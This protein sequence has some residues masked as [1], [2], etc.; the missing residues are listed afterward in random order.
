[1]R[2]EQFFLEGLGHQS[3][4]VL[5]ESAHL[6]AVVDPRRDVD[7]YLQAAEAADAR[8]GWVFETHVHNDYITGALELCERT[9]AII[10]NAASAGLAYK[11]QGARDGDRIAV[12]SLAFVVLATPGH[13]PDHLSYALY[14]SERETPT[15]VFTGGSMLVGGAGRTDLVSPGM[16]VTL[17]R[18]Q[19][20]SLRRLLDTL[21]SETLVYPT[22]GAGSFCGATADGP[23][24]RHSTIGQERLASPA[25]HAHDEAEFVRQQISGY[26]VY[27]TYYRYMGEINQ[28]GPRIL[29]G[30]PEL[31]ALTPQAVSDYL[32]HGLPLIDGRRRR[33]FAAEHVPGALNIE[34]DDSFG[35][36][37]GWLLP[38]NK[39]LMLQ[40]DD[41]TGR[42]EAVAQLIRI[43]YEQLRGH[44]EGGV[45]AWKAAGFPTRCFET[46]TIDELE[47]RWQTQ[48][49]RE[50][51]NVLDV[52]DAA[53][54]ESG[55]VVGT[56]HIHIGDLMSHLH[57][58]PLD[59][60]IVTVCRSGHRASIAASILDALGRE[61]IS[62]PRGGVPDWLAL[63]AAE[64]G[65]DAA[66]RS[67][68]SEHAH[69]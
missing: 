56:Q 12:G 29:G 20:Q 52:R 9:G 13:T 7:M 67:G 55:H 50:P 58:I 36:Y 21:P 3:Y 39:P 25:A 46:I 49:T 62:M 5:D 19:Y 60:P 15:A 26:G 66:S 16:T 68:A 27:P 6:A 1:M 28:R 40:I 30:L 38:F 45:D 10:V 43:G 59:Q 8:I 17:T 18:E 63:R 41:E 54:W 53:E 11:H 51:L 2:V 34:L 42:R 24:T 23:A 31:A 61:T 64:A 4:V 37:V 47:R 44:L 14:E 33:A 65:G 35:T 69:P 48:Q 32:A 22:H 57:E